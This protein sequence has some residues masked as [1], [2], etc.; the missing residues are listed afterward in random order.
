[1]M[2]WALSDH[3]P[4]LVE[5][6]LNEFKTGPGFWKMNTSFRRPESTKYNQRNVGDCKKS[7]C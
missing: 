6:D 1:M 3:K 5:I 2:D 7:K 4:L